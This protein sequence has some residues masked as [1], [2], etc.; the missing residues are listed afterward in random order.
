MT[1]IQT[2]LVIDGESRG[3][4]AA[5]RRGAAALDALGLAGKEVQTR[6][7]SAKASAEVFNREIE[8]SQRDVRALQAALD[9][10]AA[11][12]QRFEAAEE[13]LARAVRLGNVSVEEQRR[14]LGL[15]QAQQT[16]AA[17]GAASFAARQSGLLGIFR[18]NRFAA[19]QLGFQAQDVAVQFQAG[20]AAS[21]IFAQQGSQILGIFGPMGAILGAVL[22]VTVPLGAALFS[23]LRDPADAAEDTISSFDRLKQAV[24][25]YASAANAALIPTAGLERKYGQADGAA[26]VFLGTLLEIAQFDAR[27]AVGDQIEEILAPFENINL[28][29]IAKLKVG[30][31]DLVD[32][33]DTLSEKISENT[34]QFSLPDANNGLD[35][36]FRNL[37]TEISA[38]VEN[39]D[40]LSAELSR[41]SANGDVTSESVVAVAS[42]LRE[43]GTAE[44]PAAQAEASAALLTALKGALGTYNEM[45]EE[46]QALFLAVTQTG[47]Q[48]SKL[49]GET[50]KVADR[51]ETVTGLAV[52]FRNTIAGTDMSGLIGQA[53][54]LAARLG[55]SLDNAIGLNNALN[56]SAGIAAPEASGLGFGLPGVQDTT[57]GSQPLR[58]GEPQ[59]G[60]RR[61]VSNFLPDEKTKRSGG[62][63]NSELKRQQRERQRLIDEIRKD[64]R[65]LRSVYDDDVK[66]AEEWRKK[67]LEGLDPLAEGYSQFA[68]DVELIFQDRL[69]KAYLDDLENRDDWV[70]GIQSGLN[71]VNDSMLSWADVSSDL[72][73]SW[74]EGLEDAFVDLALTGKASIDDLVDHTLEQLA[75]LAYQ[76]AIQPAVS[77]LFDFIS[78]GIGGLFGVTTSHTGSIVGQGVSKSYP[79]GLASDERPGILKLGQ[80]VFTPSQIENGA[81]V[82]D[83]L[84]LAA[85]RPAGG[86][87]V[88]V[89]EINNYTSAE[90]RETKRP[91]GGVTID[92]M[93]QVE[94]S[95]AD[96]VNSGRG[97]LAT[98][99]KRGGL[100]PGAG[101]GVR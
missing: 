33:Y 7:T 35:R 60:F 9:P 69:K 89:V 93:G 99:L 23:S 24:D 78:G 11:A 22:A 39:F 26:R 16:G 79:N 58:F 77:G 32:Q 12:T 8:A 55:V 101:N 51:F 6:F 3:A 49:A 17:S 45:G 84:A 100:R 2:S 65:G 85:S 34:S 82:V 44:G 88:T 43:L 68:E 54:Q 63:R 75:R 56:A 96:R 10:A 73:T 27:V 40:E 48:A 30:V 13:A 80:R 67:A 36:L 81:A 25:A 19:Q 29:R 97:P 41:L 21:I 47:E 71:D 37:Q 52:D 70:A 38:T 64:V 20:T 5:A 62:G 90:V 42:A 53:A 57:V 18:Q 50:A 74:S 91:D 28:S 31:E 94:R 92:I 66:A 46:A 1:T 72:V 59:E 61:T 86:G 95:M 4:E 14:L 87:S 83:A 15:L 98:A 76:Q